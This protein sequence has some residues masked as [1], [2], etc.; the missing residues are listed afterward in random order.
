MKARLRAA[1][2]PV[3][4][5]A[6]LESAA[7][8]AAHV[9]E[10][11][12]VVAKPVD[13][14][15]ARGVLRVSADVDPRWAF[16]TARAAS[17]S[18]RAMVESFA[19]GPQISS[20]S[21]ILADRACTLACSDRN[22]EQ[23]ERFAP[24]MIEDGGVQPSVHLDAI[25][26][27]V[28]ALALRAARAIGLERG[29]LKGD[30][31]L[32]PDGELIVIEVAPRLSGGWLATDQVPLSTGIDLVAAAAR[33]AMGVELDPAEL[34]PR[35]WK[36][37]AVRYLFAPAGRLV[38]VAGFEEQARLPWVHRA[39]LF[40]RLGE[41]IGPVTDHTRRAGVVITTGATRAEAVRR[42]ED[43]VRSVRLAVERD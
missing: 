2:V 34:A 33:L 42:A 15:G 30:L 21:V 19:H 32:G 13:S 39:H 1:G 40:V 31:V 6:P 37:V 14:R 16:E 26:A 27:R 9:A 17:P 10:R 11:G 8:L 7:E 22:Y 20:E 12:V 24:W 35:H 38:G 43:A 41:R 25:L 5:F 29:V 3:P 28:D 23:L 4:W 36:P 18:N